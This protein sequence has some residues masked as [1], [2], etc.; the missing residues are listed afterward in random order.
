LPLTATRLSDLVGGVYGP[1]ASVASTGL[2]AQRPAIKAGMARAAGETWEDLLEYYMVNLHCHSIDQ[3]TAPNSPCV[4][5]RRSWRN[6]L[7][8][9]SWQNILSRQHL[10]RWRRHCIRQRRR[11]CC[12]S[13]L[14]KCTALFPPHRTPILASGPSQPSPIHTLIA[15][16]R[17][18][19]P[20]RLRRCQCRV[21]GAYVPSRRG[22]QGR[23]R[24]RKDVVRKRG[25]AWG[26]GVP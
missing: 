26:A 18:Q 17:K 1:G 21:P 3:A 8:L 23:C 22:C 12:P 16:G 25:S 20:N 10:C 9:P 11:W 7:R 6:G 19:W 14:C 4:V 13:R 24:H 15:Q 2:N 5:Q